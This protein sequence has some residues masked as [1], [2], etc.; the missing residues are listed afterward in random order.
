MSAEI[1]QTACVDCNAPITV[2]EP[3]DGD[4]EYRCGRCASD[5]TATP[6][7]RPRSEIVQSYVE[8]RRCVLYRHYDDQ[9]VL[10]YVGVSENPID[11]TNGHA[12][13]SDWVQYAMRAEMEWMDSRALAE[14]AE[15]EAIRE[16]VPVFN[17]Q[18]AAGDVDRR[19]ADYVRNRELQYLRHRVEMYEGIARRLIADVP[20]E[21][22][23]RA[24]NKARLDYDF[25]GQSIDGDL[26]A[27]VLRYLA[28]ELKRFVHE[29]RRNAARFVLD[30][31]SDRI[32]RRHELLN[33]AEEKERVEPTEP[34][35]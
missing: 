5:A 7:S 15:R 6:A 25:A 13:S 10:L 17:R 34:P 20:T 8:Q 26:P 30:D 3:E 35:F 19:I 1:V 28:G 16:D 29:S 11:R 4:T 32:A 14:V 22:R 2:Y 18:H 33:Q 21:V 31:L 9:D 23:E 12:R 27:H 24:E